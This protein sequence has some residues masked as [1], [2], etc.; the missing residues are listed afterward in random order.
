M[1]IATWNINGFRACFNKG[2]IN[3]IQKYKPDILCLQETKAHP[4][5]LKENQR[6]I[7]PYEYWSICGIKK[8]YSGTAIFSKKP[9]FNISYGM[10]IKKFDWE[11][12]VVIF[13]HKNFILINIYFPNGA[14]TLQR[15]LFKQEFLKN[16]PV[17]LKDL[18]IKKQKELIIVGDYNVAYKEFDVHSPKTLQN[19]SGFLPEERQWFE[20]FLKKGYVDVYRHFYPNKKEVYTWWSLREKARINNKGWRI[21]HICVTQKLV[22]QIQTIKILDKQLGSDH[23]PVIMD[24]KI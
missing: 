2:L 24:I 18:K 3:F 15:H 10:N 21:D 8:G 23:C 17:F 6:N 13:E 16:L 4:D 9:A 12:R 5:Q 19:T 1:L 14:L 20:E 22:K 11:G 7:Y